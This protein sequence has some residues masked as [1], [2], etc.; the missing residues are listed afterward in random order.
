MQF[1]KHLQSEQ[2]YKQLC[3]K[4]YK[5]AGQQIMAPSQTTGQNKLKSGTWF[6]PI[7]SRRKE[8]HFYQVSPS[9]MQ[10][11]E[12]GTRLNQPIL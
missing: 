11:T 3:S 10:F 7:V 5:Y 9:S 2:I 12:F 4:E 8:L 6:A 1:I